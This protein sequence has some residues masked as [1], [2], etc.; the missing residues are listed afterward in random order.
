MIKTLV[1]DKYYK[2]LED[3]S[4]DIIRIKRIKNENTF[5][6]IDN[7]NK[8][9][10][11]SKKELED[12][13]KL[14]PD[15]YITLSIVELQEKIKDVLVCIHTRKD[16]D[17]GIQIPYAVCRQN[18]YDVFTNAIN[19]DNNKT[20]VG[21]SVSIDTVPADVDY[22]M[23]VACNSVLS[24]NMI[25]IYL[26]DKYEDILNLIQRKDKYDEILSILY[27]GILNA[28]VYGYCNSL[29]QLL[30]DNN[31]MYDF[32]KAFNIEEVDFIL[33]VENEY[34]LIPEQRII[35]E[36]ILKE[37]MFQTYVLKYDKEID[38]N[39]IK[40]NYILV[41]DK[42]EDVYIVAYD[43]GEYINRAYRDNIK[44]KRDAV[45]LLKFKK[46]PTNK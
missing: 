13:I 41:S 29:N 32:H 1:G 26:D 9:V 20:Y 37:E 2:I 17:N 8:E 3:D 46:K 38:L 43:K 42:K 10:K 31:F 6:C 21:C 24:S 44:D 18:I 30:K 22:K 27:N 36:D 39:K 23:M 25:S 16:I 28:D 35:L 33:E 15:G 7:T 40:R 11:L 12:Y 4:L 19:R 14:K 34:E 5:I 45:T